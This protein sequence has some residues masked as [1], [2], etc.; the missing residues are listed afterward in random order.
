MKPR[1]THLDGALAEL[2]ALRQAYGAAQQRCTD[3]LSRLHR[4]NQ[5]LEAEVMRLRAQLMSHQTALAW[6]RED[7]AR[8]LAT[9]PGLPSRVRLAARIEAMA[10]RM[11]ALV[12]M[13]LKLEARCPP[14]A[15]AEQ[16]AAPLPLRAPS[17]A[18]Q[19]PVTAGQPAQEGPPPEAEDIPDLE[20]RL[21]EADLV[22]CQTGCLS[23]QAY[24]RMQDHCR[25]HNK[26]CVLVAQP[27]ALRIVRIHNRDRIVAAAPVMAADDATT[28]AVRRRMPD[29]MA[30]DALMDEDSR[31]DG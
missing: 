29:T 4:R 19:A 23:H 30:F 26:P 25:R 24:W 8:L 28:D 11:Q 27:E 17:V 31:H 21:V 15:E 6:A 5:E 14:P 10:V 16:E 12:R 1:Q 3:S 18:P 9:V 2:K 13:V 7:R 22:I 20:E